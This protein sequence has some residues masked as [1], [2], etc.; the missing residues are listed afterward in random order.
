MGKNPRD[1]KRF[2]SKSE[3]NPKGRSLPGI[4]LGRDCPWSVV[5]SPLSAVGGR[6][7]RALA[8]SREHRGKRKEAQRKEVK[9]ESSKIKAERINKKALD[10]IYRSYRIF[11]GSLMELRKSLSCEELLLALESALML[12]A[13]HPVM[14]ILKLTGP[15]CLLS[16]KAEEDPVC[17]VNPV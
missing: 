1:L 15:F 3:C 17:P 14:S 5:S 6:A 10:R 13:N 4:R 16:G 11:L 7:Q 9:K 12:Q 8:E 2:S